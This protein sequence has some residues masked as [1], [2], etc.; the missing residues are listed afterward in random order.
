VIG[1]NKPNPEYSAGRV[2]LPVFV[3]IARKIKSDS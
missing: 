2:A 3:E 1:F